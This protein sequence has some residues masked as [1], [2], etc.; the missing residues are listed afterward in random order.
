M[1]KILINGVIHTMAGRTVSALAIRNGHIALAGSDRE[2]LA[3]RTA[4]TEVIDLRKS[5]VLPGFT[6]SHM[7]MFLTGRSFERL[8]L[9]GVRSPEEIVRRGRDYI[10]SRHV[11]A[12]AWVVGYGYDHNQFPNPVLPDGKVA[13]AIS[14]EHPVLLD[15]ICGHVGAANPMALRLAGFGPDTM[16]PGGELDKDGTGNLT[17]VIREAALD[18]IKTFEPKPAKEELECILQE[19]G[20]RFAAAGLTAVHS[21]DLCPE[22]TDWDT[23][24]AAVSDLETQGKCQV[25]IYEEWEAP[26]PEQLR[27]IL[28]QGLY[29]GWGDDW[30]RLANIKLITDGS[31][32]ARTA[33]LRAGYQDEAENRGIPVY[34]QQE[35]DEMTALCHNRGLQVAF[36]AIGDGA[37]EQCVNAVEK[38]MAAAPKPLRHRIVHCQIGDRGLYR[39]MAALGMGADI[40]PPFTVSDGPLV[41]PRLGPERAAESYAWRTLLDCGISLGG[42]SDSPVESYKPLWGIY[43]A[44]TRRCGTDSL[45]WLPEQRLSVRQAVSLYTSGPAWLAH[46][47][48]RTGTLEAGKLADLVVLDRDIFTVQPEEIKNLRVLRTMAGGRV[49]WNAEESGGQ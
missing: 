23:L 41:E 43:C 42:G 6:D 37:L 16:I 20:R 24:R 28:K 36:H 39:R 21:D 10:R 47:E 26:H 33:F 25:R 2:A 15:R 27:P 17:G 45:P 49:T 8:D 35:L 14:A 11:P 4:D 31:L 32:G 29:S 7:H 48:D 12:G 5:C 34:T 9:R 40:Q 44:V 3:L 18:L 13:Q 38:A 19:A 46:A 30:L 1:D 22:G